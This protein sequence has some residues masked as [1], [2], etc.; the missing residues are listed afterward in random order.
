MPNSNLTDSVTT[1]RLGPTITRTATGITLNFP[2][3][4]AP[5]VALGLGGFAFLC[6]VMPALGLSALLPIKDASAF[7]S[8]A[9]IGG[10]AAP[11]MLAA[12]VFAVLAVYLLANSLFVE[13]DGD[14]VRT[15][16]RVFGFVTA[17][18]AITRGTIADIEPR[19]GARY[20]NVFSSVPRYSLIARNSTA[21]NTDVIVAEDLA[22]QTLMRET[23]SLLMAALGITESQIIE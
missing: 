19:I 10:L 5:G 3:L 21:N 23:R 13:I 7:V 20:Q 1:Q 18:H 14:G 16:R 4:R 15:T 12:V 6:G 11:F 17:T 8:L 2:V 22:G 9:L